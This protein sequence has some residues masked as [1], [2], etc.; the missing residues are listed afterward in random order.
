MSQI[1]FP[2]NNV[3]QPQVVNIIFQS[4]QTSN[5]FQ[6]LTENMF[7]F[8]KAICFNLVDIEILNVFNKNDS[9]H[10]VCSDVTFKYIFA[11][12][13][14][15]CVFCNKKYFHFLDCGNENFACNHK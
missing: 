15:C 7:C 10:F 4:F 8:I 6:L 9:M 3:L 11:R 13:C 12:S 1:L 14:R 5:D 2:N